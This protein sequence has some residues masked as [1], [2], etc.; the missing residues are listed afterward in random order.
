[1]NWTNNYDIRNKISSVSQ[2]IAI[3]SN[4]ETGIASKGKDSYW[5]G[6]ISLM[7]YRNYFKNNSYESK[8]FDHYGIAE[9]MDVNNITNNVSHVTDNKIFETKFNQLHVSENKN[10]E[11]KND[12]K[13]Y[14]TQL[15]LCLISF[16][17]K[18]DSATMISTNSSILNLHNVEFNQIIGAVI[19]VVSI[20]N[21]KVLFE[22]MICNILTYE[23]TTLLDIS[24]DHLVALFLKMLVI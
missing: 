23:N 17:F 18:N 4:K 11:D 6:E 2:S 12:G 21:R 10:Q 13:I 24:A 22:M 15:K 3:I 14:F 20:T 19:L 1:M 9:C 16:K 8:L 5:Q 7:L